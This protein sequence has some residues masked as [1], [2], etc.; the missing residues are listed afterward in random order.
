MNV[1]LNYKY[2][3]LI[4]IAISKYFYEWA[5]EYIKRGD[6]ASAKYCFRHCLTGKPINK[7][8]SL[9]KLLKTGLKLYLPQ[10]VI[11]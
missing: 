1:N 8:I 5:E 9:K 6:V 11:L 2:D 4:K 10:F 7:F 3:R